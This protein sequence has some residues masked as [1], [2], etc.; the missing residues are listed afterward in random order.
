MKKK[1]NPPEKTAFKT[2]NSFGEKVY[3]PSV[4]KADFKIKKTPTIF[5]LKSYD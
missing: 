2:V 3:A 4:T 5:I 1:E